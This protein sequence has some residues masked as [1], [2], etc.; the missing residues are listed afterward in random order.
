MIDVLEHKPTK[1]TD[2]LVPQGYWEVLSKK[3][4]SFKHVK[5]PTI[6]IDVDFF[7][8]FDCLPQKTAPSTKEKPND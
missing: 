7:T 3:M 8:Q 2:E 6:D 4:E 5:E 1:E